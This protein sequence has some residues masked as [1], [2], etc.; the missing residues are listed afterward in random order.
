M[1]KLYKSLEATISLQD[2]GTSWAIVMRGPK[3][4]V[5]WL[6]NAFVNFGAFDGTGCTPVYTWN[7]TETEAIFYS[8]KKRMLKF[9][10][11]YLENQYIN[12]CQ[13]ESIARFA[14]KNNAILFIE[15]LITNHREPRS[16][17]YHSTIVCDDYSMG[18][19]KNESPDDNLRDNILRESK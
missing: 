3:Q 8:S 10:E 12:N 19:M 2:L 9:F 7:D 17:Q 15:D 5:N 14:A 18:A 1:M 6:F 11:G 13:D 16:Q 4:E